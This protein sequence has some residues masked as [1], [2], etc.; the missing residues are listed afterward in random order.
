MLVIVGPDL[1][2]LRTARFSTFVGRARTVAAMTR[3][4]YKSKTIDAK[5]THR[6]DVDARVGVRGGADGRRQGLRD[7]SWSDG[8]RKAFKT[9]TS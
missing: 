3:Q 8:Q 4:G 7:T 5:G 2:N 6:V 9:R 1:Q